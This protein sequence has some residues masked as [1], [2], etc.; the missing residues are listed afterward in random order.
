MID[1][2]LNID[3][4]FCSGC[5][6]CQT[7]CPTKAITFKTDYKGLIWPA[8]NW[9]KCIKCNLCFRVC[10][11]KEKM[12]NSEIPHVNELKSLAYYGYSL[13]SFLRFES[14]SGGIVSQL[15]KDALKNGIV[16]IVVCASQKKNNEILINYLKRE[17]AEFLPKGSI[18][19]QVVLL[20]D[21]IEKI[22]E[23]EAKKLL[24]IGLPCH[25]GAV[26]ALHKISPRLKSKELYTIS[27]F[28]K[29]TKDERFSDFIR[30]YLKVTS[31]NE[32][33]NY[34]GGGWPGIT[35]I[36]GKKTA[37]TDFKFG[38]MWG[39][40]CFTPDYCMKCRD[41]LGANS[42][43][44]VGD[45]WLKE[46]MISDNKGSSFFWVHSKKGSQLFES[47]KNHIFFREE[48]IKNVIKS[49]SFKTL[50]DK[51]ELS[52]K[53]QKERKLGGKL[54]RIRKIAAI[55]VSSKIAIYTPSLL[56]KAFYR[57]FLR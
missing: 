37:S 25:I 47:A 38:F 34:R 22:E 12:E 17:D 9:D 50:K 52:S 6:A 19:R 23:K 1:K 11:L 51:E 45:A 20:K 39:T 30:Y 43:I 28:C 3:K 44:S 32:M 40:F 15:A 13:D 24:V 33:I 26:K 14:A 56:L 4:N 36:G 31:K 27:L 8:I 35:S 7:I 41:A 55:I 53:F 29:Q 42:D 10:S 46:Y 21:Y 54:L 49:Q 18:Y 57:I 5:G 16:D 2:N 48:Q